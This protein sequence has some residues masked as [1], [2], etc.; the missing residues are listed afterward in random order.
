[1]KLVRI[2]ADRASD[3]E[4]DFLRSVKRDGCFRAR[5]NG[6]G[7]ALARNLG[8]PNAFLRCCDAQSSFGAA[9]HLIKWVAHTIFSLF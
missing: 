3:S 9:E 5:L 7:P 4:S 8:L 2:K 1:M 6:P